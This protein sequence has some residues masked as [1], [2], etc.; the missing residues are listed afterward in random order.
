MHQK[1]ATFKG[2]GSH[3]KKNKIQSTKQRESREAGRVREK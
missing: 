1:R 2:K 3:I